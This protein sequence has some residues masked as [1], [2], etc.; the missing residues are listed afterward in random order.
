MR[1]QTWIQKD[2]T[3]LMGDS[4]APVGW[5]RGYGYGFPLGFLKGSLTVPEFMAEKSGPNLPK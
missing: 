4:K 5:K 2:E 3:R 1:E